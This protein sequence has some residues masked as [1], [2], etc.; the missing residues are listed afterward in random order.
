MREPEEAALI[1]FDD[2]ELA[3]ILH[4]KVTVVRQPVDEIGRVAG[5]VALQPAQTG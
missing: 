5:R 2:F 4:P 3:E 1:C